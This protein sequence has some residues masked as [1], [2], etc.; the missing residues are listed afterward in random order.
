MNSAGAPL[1]PSLRGSPNR[2]MLNL[3][4]FSSSNGGCQAPSS[5]H[6]GKGCINPTG[7]FAWL[8]HFHSNRLPLP[9]PPLHPRDKRYS[10]PPRKLSPCFRVSLASPHCPLPTPGGCSPSLSK[11]APAQRFISSISSELHLWPQLSLGSQSALPPSSYQVNSI[12]FCC[13]QEQ[14]LGSWQGWGQERLPVL[15]SSETQRR[16]GTFNN[17]TPAMRKQWDPTTITQTLLQALCTYQVKWKTFWLGL[18]GW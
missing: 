3:L 7:G 5:W 4:H 11:E 12:D 15:A 17:C 18:T 6:P 9:P 8:S 16:N 2:T 1:S 13:C 10:N 14:L